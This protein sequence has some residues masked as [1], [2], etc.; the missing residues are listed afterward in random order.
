M[1]KENKQTTETSQTSS[2]APWSA[3]QPLLSSLISKYGGM[4]TD[5][6]GQQQTALNNLNTSAEAIP[7]NMGQ[8]SSGALGQLF[9][10][11]TQ[12]QQ[13]VLTQALKT[14][15]GN[16][17]PSADP[18]NLN[19]YNTP[20]FS[21]AMGTAT[22]DAMK[23]IKSVYA[24]SGRDPSG[25]GSFAGSAGRGIMQATAPIL[26]SQFNINRQNQQ[27]AAGG[28]LSGALNTEGAVTGQQQAPLTAALSGIQ[29]APTAAGNYML[30]ATAQYGAANTNYQQPWLNL[31]SLLQ[32]A[33]ALGSMGSQSQGQGTSTTSQPQNTLSN[34][35]GGI[36]GGLGIL[37]Q[38]MPL[39][40]SDERAK[41]DIEKIGKTDDNQPIYRFR[42]K[43]TP[44]TQ[45]GL[46][47]QDVLKRKPDAVYQ[48]G[49]RGGMLMVDLK[50]ATDDAARA[51]A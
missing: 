8:L 29:A 47:A 1:A 50:G 40:M 25:A 34:V 11:N 14:Y 27:G 24:G 13:D 16:M 28:L 30:P 41:E 2:T 46:L 31:A 15:Q 48:M 51:A 3:A 9:S 5:V 6:T 23:A 49:G 32:P 37:G 22:S 43:G 20:G 36:S 12:P 4:S 19:P 17:A 33:V 38:M 42:Y 7:T 39:M 10:M 35:M 18:A 44:T 21:D 26:Q 45:I